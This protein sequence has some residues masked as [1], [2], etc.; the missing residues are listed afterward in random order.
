MRWVQWAREL[1]GGDIVTVFDPSPGSFKN[2]WVKYEFVAEGVHTRLVTKGA[3]TPDFALPGLIGSLLLKNNLK[4]AAV[5]IG[6]AIERKGIVQTVAA[7]L[8]SH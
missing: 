6:R 8:A 2:G 4:H 1:P 7:N 5:E 3:L